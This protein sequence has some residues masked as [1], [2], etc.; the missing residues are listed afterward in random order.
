M[1]FQTEYIEAWRAWR[2]IDGELFSL[3]CSDLPGGIWKWSRTSENRAF[4]SAEKSHDAPAISCN[5]GFHGLKERSALLDYI[6]KPSNLIAVGRV[7]FYGTV[8]HGEAGYRA[9]HA[10]IPPQQLEYFI[11]DNSLRSLKVPPQATKGK[12]E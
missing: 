2:V 7:L 8:I 12:Q 4:C 1:K 5:C 10:A 6:P 3:F 9:S 11:R